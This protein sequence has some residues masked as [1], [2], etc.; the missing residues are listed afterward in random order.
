MPQY[1]V[2]QSPRLSGEVPVST[3]KNA[4]LPILAAALLTPEEVLI[5]QVPSLTDVHHMMGILRACGAETATQGSTAVL[6][7]VSVGSPHEHA[8]LRT[9]RASVLVL[10]PILAR[11]GSCELSMPGGCAIGQRPIDLH[12]KG[13]QKLGAKVE[14]DGGTVR[15]SGALKGANIYL[16]FPSVGATENLLM[17]AVLSKGVTRIENAAKEPEITDLCHFLTAMGARIAGAGTANLTVEGVEGLHGAAYTPIPDR[18]EAGTLACA[19]AL[20]EGSVLLESARSDHMRALLFKLTESGLI[21]QEDARGLRL[22]G[23][24][25]HPME[26]RTLSYPGFPTDLQAPLMTVACQTHG[27]SVFL[28]TIF[29]NRYMHV[30]EL[31]RLGAQIRVEGQ[32]ALIQGGKPLNGGHVTA[33]DLRAAAALMLAGLIA[34]GETVVDDPAGHLLRGY[35]GLE[36]KL[37]A[38]GA[39]AVRLVESP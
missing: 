2:T 3:S 28:E 4:V 14:Q 19:A 29:E 21:C 24:A 34:Q 35:E 25:R 22:R 6:R 11:T 36:N 33:T 31:R 23:K 10:G 1:K 9:M 17:A 38:L 16:D 26:A 18:I 27:L 37:R 12:L 20:T 13:L 15:V 8:L 5:H 7:A 32:L 30:I 39:D